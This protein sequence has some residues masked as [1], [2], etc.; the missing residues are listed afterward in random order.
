[1]REAVGRGQGRGRTDH[2]KG[3]GGDR[4]CVVIGEDSLLFKWYICVDINVAEGQNH[5]EI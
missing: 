4:G 1:M 3:E 5:L 2:R